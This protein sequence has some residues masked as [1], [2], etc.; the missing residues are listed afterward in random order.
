MMSAFVLL[1]CL[2]QWFEVSVR[3]IA[4]PHLLIGQ[5]L[6]A[7]EH[8]KVVGRIG[9]KQGMIP[10]GRTFSFI[11]DRPEDTYSKKG[12]CGVQILEDFSVEFSEMFFPTKFGLMRLGPPYGQDRLGDNGTR[13]DPGAAEDG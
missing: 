9:K 1:E 13:N 7:D 8:G 10:T 4:V 3:Y 12:L 11:F 6:S 5:Q 2:E